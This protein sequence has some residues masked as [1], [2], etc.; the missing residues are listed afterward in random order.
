MSEQVAHEQGPGKAGS[1][2]VRAWDL[3]TRLFHWT[4]VLLMIGAYLSRRLG[5]PSMTWSGGLPKL[6]F[7]GTGLTWHK[8]IGYA[9]LILIVYRVLW[10][11][12]GGSTARF[13]AF[14]AGPAK[15]L[16]YGRDFASGRPRHF[17]GHN[18]LGGTM[19][20]VLLA[21]LAGQAML[22]LMS[23]D[24]HDT[25][26]GGALASRVGDAWSAVFTRWHM[27]AFDVILILVAAHIAANLVYLLWKRENL[28]R[29]M[30]TG[31]KPAKAYEDQRQAE[32]GSCGRALVCLVVAAIFVLGTVRLVAGRVF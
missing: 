10:G 22:G 3:P 20:I 11:F 19:V 29:P 16:G 13:S 17:L 15:A 7:D 24:D 30:V 4:L 1:G 26:D 21:A 18:P 5:D 12:V 25:M 2:D 28:I 31:R 9:I 6:A 32:F 27:K 14:V 23:Y 8:G